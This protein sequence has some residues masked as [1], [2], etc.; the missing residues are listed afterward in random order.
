[1]I[2]EV[3]DFC[4]IGGSENSEINIEG[5]KNYCVDSDNEVENADPF[6]EGGSD[7]H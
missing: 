5:L 2:Q 7:S 3:R 6:D 1:M 4:S